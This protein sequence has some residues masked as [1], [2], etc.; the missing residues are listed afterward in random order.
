MRLGYKSLTLSY[1]L[2]NTT[3][4]NV[5]GLYVIFIHISNTYEVWNFNWNMHSGTH[6]LAHMHI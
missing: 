4:P 1:I 3:N 6:E 2:P 5:T